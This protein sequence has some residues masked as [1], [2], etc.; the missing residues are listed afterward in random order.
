MCILCGV[1]RYCIYMREGV[2]MCAYICRVRRC[3]NVCVWICDSLN[4]KTVEELCDNGNIREGVLLWV[5][6]M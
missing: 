2:L 3:S 4:D 1:R 5:Y 6:I